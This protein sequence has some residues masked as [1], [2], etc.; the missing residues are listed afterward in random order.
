MR[1][2]ASFLGGLCDGLDRIDDE[3]HGDD[4][5]PMPHFGWTIRYKRQLSCVSELSLGYYTWQQCV[6]LA[7]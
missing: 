2:A 6:N 3:L 5:L 7:S 4:P 1:P